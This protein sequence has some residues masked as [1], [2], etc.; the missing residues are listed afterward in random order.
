MVPAFVLMI[1]P[2]PRIPISDPEAREEHR[3]EESPK[4]VP[5]EAMTGRSGSGSGGPT[6]TS[7]PVPC[8]SGRPALR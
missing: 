7:R 5:I 6:E 3:P 4:P 2:F 8:E 1:P